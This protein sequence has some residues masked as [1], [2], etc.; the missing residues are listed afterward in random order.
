MNLFNESEI[1]LNGMNEST[2]KLI[3]TEVEAV[4]DASDNVRN[5]VISIPPHFK[6]VTKLTQ[7]ES[8][9]SKTVLP[10]ISVENY[11]NAT[12]IP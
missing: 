9:V 2:T 10:F 3:P 11:K 1:D 4:Y 12:K 5:L 8:P 6:L 7:V